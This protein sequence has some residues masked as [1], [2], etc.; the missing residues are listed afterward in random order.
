MVEGVVRGVVVM[1]GV[2]R[3]EGLHVAVHVPIIADQFTLRVTAPELVH[4]ATPTL[5]KHTEVSTI[6]L[7]VSLVCFPTLFGEVSSLHTILG[8]RSPTFKLQY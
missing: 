4:Q 1:L 3:G 5:R 6:G 7:P 8:N 2:V